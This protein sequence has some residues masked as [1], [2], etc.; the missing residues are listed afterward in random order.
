MNIN[1][2]FCALCR[3]YYRLKI[4]RIPAAVDCNFGIMKMKK[5]R[6]RKERDKNDEIRPI[7]AKGKGIFFCSE[8]NM[9]WA[10]S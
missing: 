10:D 2:N 3:Q 7:L 8:K 6:K 9:P 1:C 5:F 4:E